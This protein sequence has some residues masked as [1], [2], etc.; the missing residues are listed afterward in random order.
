MNRKFA[1]LAVVG[2]LIALAAPASSMGAMYP[3]GHKFEITSGGSSGQKFETSLGSCVITKISGQTPSPAVNGNFPIS[4]P[5]VGECTTGTSVTLSGT[6]KLAT[7]TTAKVG[8][9]GEGT[10]AVT[11]R[12]S[13]LPGCKLTANVVAL[14]GIWSNGTTTPSLMKSSFTPESGFALTWADDGAS[15]ALRGT[16]EVLEFDAVHREPSEAFQAVMSTVTDL[17]NPNT[18]LL[19][20]P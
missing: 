5:T 7:G 9:V 18:P 13:S 2:A 14:S 17:T 19:V 12:F 15:C 1:L 6:W 20:G 4:T 16:R 11:M 3:T 10:N 8:L